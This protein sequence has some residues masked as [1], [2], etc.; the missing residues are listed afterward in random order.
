MSADN[1][2][3]PD[4]GDPAARVPQ[5]RFLSWRVTVSAGALMACLVLAA[6][7][8]LTIWVRSSF[9]VND[10]GTATLYQGSCETSEVATLW[11]ELVIN[12]LSTLLLGASNVCSQLLSAPTRA[13]I[14][15]AH[16]KGK[17]LDIGVPSMRNIWHIPRWRACL[18]AILMLSSI[19]LHLVYNSVVFRGQAL[20]VYQAELVTEDFVRGGWYNNT[21][22]L[23]SWRVNR[24][25]IIKQMQAS[26]IAGNLTRLENAECLDVYADRELPTRWKN[27]L[28][29][30]S[31]K[32]NS[33]L[34]DTRPAM[35]F[36]IDSYSGTAGEGGICFADD[37]YV[38]DQCEIRDVNGTKE[39]SIINKE[40]C[41]QDLCHESGPAPVLYC[42]AEPFA[43]LCTVEINLTLLGIVIAFNVVK[44]CCLITTVLAVRFQPL[45][46][47]GDAIA[48][49]LD[50]PDHTTANM[51]PVSV[52]A[53]KRGQMSMVKNE[54]P[55]TFKPKPRRWARAVSVSRWVACLLLCAGILI[56][57]LVLLRQAMEG[58]TLESF[59]EGFSGS[60]S[61]RMP[62]TVGAP[63][64]ANVIL[65]NTPQ[66]AVSLVYLFYNNIFT[67]MVLAHEYANFAT[68]RKPLRVSRAYGLQRSTLWLQLPYHYVI[69]MMVAMG[70]MHWFIS[71]SLYLIQLTMYNAHGQ[72]DEGPSFK[73]CGF[74]PYPIILALALG[75]VMVTVLIGLSF[76]R[77]PPE[78]P[79]AAS[80]SLAI[81]SATYAARDEVDAAVMPL[82]YGVLK[83]SAEEV[84][85]DSPPRVGF[86][87]Y[88]VE[89]LVKGR[90]YT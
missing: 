38:N 17:W 83:A 64:L 79:I 67:C 71:R 40:L 5:S 58:N 14:N 32:F 85:K 59:T 24:P 78:I 10:E 35:N 63:L 1:E 23:S 46:T 51:G 74:S 54:R 75:L 22:M 9:E 81:S 33:S 72:L 82:Q 68:K 43:P 89:P 77:L 30:T 42:L 84:E 4:H 50:F 55:C 19:P 56:A 11:P 27:V 45:S 13:D 62:A 76:R 36:N 44:I 87:R 34:I 31:L 12:L 61:N 39:W 28:V 90:V 60:P 86:S 88:H 70:F 3:H 48:S 69:P 41:D 7:V 57:G 73:G 15:R 21:G 47:I 37:G 53:G 25:S 52:L 6:N 2:K 16:A 18:W 65:T 66:I 80:C 29:V 8:G 26:A 20:V 49:F